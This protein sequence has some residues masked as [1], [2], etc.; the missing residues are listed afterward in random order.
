M[1]TLDGYPLAGGYI[2]SAFGTWSAWRQEMGLPPHGGVDIAT[3][4]DPTLRAIA[5]GTVRWKAYDGL[6]GNYI[7][8]ATAGGGEYQYLHMKSMSP[9]AIGTVVRRGDVLGT[10]G[11][12][13]RVDGAHVH[14]NYTPRGGGR[15]PFSDAL[16][17]FT[18]SGVLRGKISDGVSGVTW[19]GGTVA[20]LES[21]LTANVITSA[22]A[23]VGGKAK[24]LIP[25]A[26]AFVN[27]GFRDVFPGT[28][29]AGTILIVAT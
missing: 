1:G 25:G 23:H 9:L 24:V 21:E 27:K 16:P 29:P 26:P 19:G 4:G 28:V 3:R 15:V 8:V 11:A 13:G 14:L 6:T 10:M 12:T 22:T 2:T 18:D 20:E 7:A 17:Y 5:P